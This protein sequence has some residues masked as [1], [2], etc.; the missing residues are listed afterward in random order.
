SVKR[1][2][3]SGV[4]TMGRPATRRSPAAV[5]PAAV[6][7]AARTEKTTSALVTGEPSENF[8]P[9]RRVIVQVSGL[10]DWTQEAASLGSSSPLASSRNRVDWV[11]RLNSWLAAVGA[12]NL[13]KFV[14]SV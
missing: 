11:S 6:A 4:T 3:S 2:S 12:A 14:G 1:A 7:N 13:R 10:P 5:L 8:A 9:G